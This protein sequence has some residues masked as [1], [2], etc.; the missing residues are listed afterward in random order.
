LGR[1]AGVKDNMDF[2]V[3][4]EGKVIKHPKTG[5]VIDVQRIETGKIRIISVRDK[6]AEAE[7]IKEES[8]GSIAYGQLVSS[9]VGN[10]Q[11]VVQTAPAKDRELHRTLSSEKS[12]K[13]GESSGDVISMLKSSSMRDKEAAAKI[14][15]KKYRNDQRI[16]DIVDDELLKS[17]NSST[18]DRDFVDAMAWLCNALGASGQTKYRSTLETVSNSASNKKLKKYAYKNLKRLR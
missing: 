11:P 2:S 15:A 7:I 14:V 9:I 3:Y 6:V 16:L 5:A 18:G 4:K 17:Y 13:K 8:P 1:M 12:S 10:L